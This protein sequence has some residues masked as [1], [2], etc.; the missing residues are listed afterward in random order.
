MSVS[1]TISSIGGTQWTVE[2]DRAAPVRAAK[3]ALQNASQIPWRQ[4]RLLFG[5]TELRDKEAL[6]VFV[7][8]NEGMVALTLIHRDPD[9]AAW[10]EQVDDSWL[11]LQRAPP[12]V[13]DDSD[14][15]LAALAQHDNA[16]WFASPALMDDVDFVRAAA[17]QRGW[18]D[19]DALA[20]GL[21]SRTSTLVKTTA[22]AKLALQCAAHF[23]IADVVQAILSVGVV[24][25][26]PMEDRLG[27]ASALARA[28]TDGSA[29]SGLLRQAG[30]NDIAKAMCE[31]VLRNLPASLDLLDLALTA[32][33]TSALGNIYNGIASWIGGIFRGSAK[34]MSSIASMSNGPVL[35]HQDFAVALFKEHAGSFSAGPSPDVKV[36]FERLLG[37]LEGAISQR[38]GDLCC[39]LVRA[40]LVHQL[41]EKAHEMFSKIADSSDACVEVLVESHL[42]LTVI[43][44]L[45][46]RA[47]LLTK[48]IRRWGG[49]DVVQE[50]VASNR[51]AL[52]TLLSSV[53]RKGDVA[54]G[55]LPVLCVALQAAAQR[56]GEAEAGA[57]GATGHV[58][59]AVHH[60]LRAFAAPAPQ[61]LPDFPVPLT[62]LRS[63]RGVSGCAG[64]AM[65]RLLAAWE[66]VADDADAVKLTQDSWG[67]VDWSEASGEQAERAVNALRRWGRQGAFQTAD[68]AGRERE[69]SRLDL[70][71]RLGEALFDLPLDR[72]P[73][74]RALIAPELP[75]HGLLAAS[76]DRQRQ[77]AAR[78]EQ[79]QAD[80]QRMR[81]DLD[82]ARAS[83][84]TANNRANEAASH[85]DRLESELR[86]LSRRVDGLAAR[87]GS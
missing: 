21:R 69:A 44:K 27:L 85:A 17:R 24:E 23:G 86:M 76:L 64:L 22:D 48:T 51:Q 42:P 7:P 73:D 34:Q 87:P 25:G 68:L 4:Q 70:E 46:D 82:D 33:A 16:L 20:C 80:F 81:S 14:I 72:L 15:V 36:N 79:M 1:L 28:T 8:A 11:N 43:E 83:A 65:D 56:H 32:P 61:Q 62:W 59:P 39:Q 41:D 31:P 66:A 18:P 71:R 55:R 58:S 50:A 2:A 13:K 84:R 5:V 63:L 6:G 49:S 47:S 53:E 40:C 3:E 38:D 19:G 35:S 26:A 74:P 57:L 37:H 77:M 54:L 75:P 60:L 29:L 78:I 45:P 10:L 9:K 12:E 52:R 30:R 67:L